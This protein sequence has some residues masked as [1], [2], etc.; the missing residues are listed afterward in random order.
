MKLRFILIQDPAK[1]MKNLKL[2][3]QTRKKL[4]N[5]ELLESN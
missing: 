5:L 1:R 3:D 2:F 4:K